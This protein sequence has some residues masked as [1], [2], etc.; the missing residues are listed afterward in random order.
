MDNKPISRREMFRYIGSAG[1]ATMLGGVA[2]HGAEGHTPATP[3][4]PQVPRRILGKT[5]RSVPILL[6]GGAMDF[7]PKFDARLAE[8]LRFGVNYIDEADCY[9]NGTS[10][11]RFGE[12]LAN[13][14]QR[15][16]WWITTKSCDKSPSGLYKSVHRSLEKMKV[17]DVEL[18][19]M[20]GLQDPKQLSDEM[21][22]TAEKLKKEGKIHFFGFSCHNQNVAELLELAATLP[23]IDVIMFRYNFRE[24]GNEKLNR[25]IDAAHKANIGLIAMKTQGSGVSFEDRIA[26]FTSDRYTRGQAVLKAVWADERITAAV[27]Q[28]NTFEYTKE[29]IAAALDKH[30]LTSVEVESLH[31]Y[32]ETTKHLYC[33]GCEHICNAAVP[34]GIQIGTTLRYLMYH[35]TYGDQDLAR[36]EFG[37]LPK[38]SQQIQGVDYSQA[39]ALCPH[40][41]DIAKHMERAAQV[42]V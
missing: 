35:D 26:K 41:I 13:H 42:F 15:K 33:A 28:M 39:M 8:C 14:K 20:H 18:V 1:L 23:W 12:Y 30:N 4:L 34:N 36:Y 11:V 40:K 24:Y 7:N 29:N 25:A 19:F 2:A 31:Q 5:G 9:Q 32:A 16:D 10:E 22:A 27:S 37:M 17:E 6:M 21:K 38:E 3:K